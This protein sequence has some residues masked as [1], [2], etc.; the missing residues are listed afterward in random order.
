MN[1]YYTAK[2]EPYVNLFNPHSLD[3]ILYDDHIVAEEAKLQ[4]LVTSR[5]IKDVCF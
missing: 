3:G 1:D 4:L 5:T 2:D